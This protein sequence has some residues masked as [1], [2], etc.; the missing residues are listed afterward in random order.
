MAS[1]PTASAEVVHT[2]VFELRG[3][4]LQPEIPVPFEVKPTVPVG[5]GGPEGDTVAVMVTC[6]PMVEGLGALV[7]AVMV[8]VGIERLKTEPSPVLPPASVVP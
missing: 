4:A 5:A 8:I 7:T 6:C 2:A 1:V 3:T